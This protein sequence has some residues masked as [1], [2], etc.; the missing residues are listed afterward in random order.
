[1]LAYD[2]DN[3]EILYQIDLPTTANGVKI[4]P[5]YRTVAVTT[6]DTNVYF[7]SPYEALHTEKTHPVPYRSVKMFHNPVAQSISWDP[8]SRYVAFASEGDNACIVYDMTEEKIIRRYFSPV[9]NTYL[10]I[11][12][13]ILFLKFINLFSR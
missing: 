3:Q 1:M 2:V 11:C 10:Q 6:D 5:D 4:S 8:T 12:E 13:E 9:R 7:F